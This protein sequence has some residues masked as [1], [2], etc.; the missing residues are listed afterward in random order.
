MHETANDPSVAVLQSQMSTMSDTVS[1]IESKLDV[2]SQLFVTKSEF[3][4][5]KQRWFYSHTLAA[6]TG[7]TMSGLL[8]YI[9]TK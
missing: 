6:A 9:L 4:E 8:V 1:R 7:A 5:F 3:T 2:F